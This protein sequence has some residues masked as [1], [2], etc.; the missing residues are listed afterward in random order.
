MLHK[1]FFDR[2]VSFLGLL[3]IWPLLLIIALLVRAKIGSPVF[4][5]QERIG[6]DGKPFKMHKFH[7]MTDG[8]D[9]SPISIAGE[10]RITPFG[11]KLR[12]YKMD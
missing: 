8:L 11:A 10:A 3:I 4:F 5:V 1:P 9:E 7:T 6:K 2:I 12:R